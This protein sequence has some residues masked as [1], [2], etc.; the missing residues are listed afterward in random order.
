MCVSGHDIQDLLH[1]EYFFNIKTGDASELIKN[2]SSTE[3]L[4]LQESNTNDG[5]FPK[6]A[7]SQSFIFHFF[8]LPLVKINISI[9]ND[10]H[11]SFM[12]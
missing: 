4:I 5:T 9:R 6:F 3:D 10:K 11:E 7:Q 12:R 2:I 1:L 8:F